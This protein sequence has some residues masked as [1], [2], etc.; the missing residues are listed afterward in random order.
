L[1]KSGAMRVLHVF[2]VR[3]VV[4]AVGAAGARFACCRPVGAAGWCRRAAWSSCS[5]EALVL[6]SRAMS[7]SASAR[8]ARMRSA[9]RVSSSAAMRASGGGAVCSSRFRGGSRLGRGRFPRRPGPGRGRRAA[10][11]RS[12]PAGS[13]RLSCSAWRAR[14]VGLGDL[15]IGVLSGLADVAFRGGPCVL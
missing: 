2:L 10:G 14:P 5:G 15:A 6:G 12:L 4:L 3:L 13:V 7:R 11:R 8:S 9:V 1:G